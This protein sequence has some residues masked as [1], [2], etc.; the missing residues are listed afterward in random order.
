[1][2]LL[3]IMMSLDCLKVIENNIEIDPKKSCE[4]WDLGIIFL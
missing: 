3:L 1:M 4:S 2:Q